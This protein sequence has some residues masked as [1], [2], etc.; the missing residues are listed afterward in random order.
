[1]EGDIM[2]EPLLQLLTDDTA[3]EPALSAF[4]EAARRGVPSG[5]AMRLAIQMAASIAAAQLE[6]RRRVA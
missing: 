4:L 3:V 1:M 5:V 2:Q 6:A